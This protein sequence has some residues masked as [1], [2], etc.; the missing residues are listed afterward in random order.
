MQPAYTPDLSAL[1]AR[2][3]RSPF[4]AWL[5]LQLVSGGDGEAVLDLPWNDLFVSTPERQV[6]HGG[7]LAA[8][9]DAAAI[10]ALICSTG[11]LFATVDLRIDYHAGARPGLLRASAKALRTGRALST[12]EARV[13][14]SSGQ[15]VASGRGLFTALDLP[16]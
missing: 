14:D 1:Q 10:Y 11:R 13:T 2:L 7:I 12:S 9:I 8:L 5:G 4:N 6:A 15:M 3:D 16:A